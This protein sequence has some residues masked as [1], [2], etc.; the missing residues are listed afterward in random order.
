[1]EHLA[2]TQTIEKV[3]KKIIEDMT[4]S[5]HICVRGEQIARIETKVDTILANQLEIKAEVKRTLKQ[6]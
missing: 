5:G 1:V 6:D 2:L 3:S 4:K